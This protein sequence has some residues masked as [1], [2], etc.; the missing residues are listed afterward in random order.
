MPGSISP[1]NLS[2]MKPKGYEDYLTLAEVCRKVEKDETWIKRLERDKKIPVAKRVKFRHVMMRLWSPVQVKEIE[3]I[4]AAN[5][6][7]RPKSK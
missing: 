5:K 7:G 4:L 3:R 2:F 1:R 6:P